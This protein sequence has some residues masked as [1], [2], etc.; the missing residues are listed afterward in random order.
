[1]VKDLREKTGAGMMDCKNALKETNGDFEKAVDFLR[2]KGLA[3]AAKKATR[4][5]SEGLIYSYIHMNKIG[6][7]IELNCET[8]F[9]AKTDEFTE[10]A[11]DIAMHIAAANPSFL[12]KDSVP[13]ETINREKEIYKDQVINK[14]ANV[15]EKILE[16]KL[17]KFYSENCLMSQIFV[18]DTEQKKT[19]TDLITDKI[20]KLGE[21]IILRRFVRF[22]IG[23]TITKS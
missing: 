14:P 22:Q 12:D 4:T 11:K 20:A 19:I 7:M 1:M 21:N 23:E 5:A 9:V 8:D 18:K 16:G 13:P 2:K 17:E 15:I 6:V 3:S 10:L